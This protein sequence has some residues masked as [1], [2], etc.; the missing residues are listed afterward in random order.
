ML[1]PCLALEVMLSY[2][3]ARDGKLVGQTCNKLDK[4]KVVCQKVCH[5][6]AVA[7]KN[8]FAVITLLLYF[9]CMIWCLPFNITVS[10]FNL[11]TDN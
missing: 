3:P 5:A 7:K 6:F 1:R 8:H 10:F 4:F 2:S 9:L 11:L